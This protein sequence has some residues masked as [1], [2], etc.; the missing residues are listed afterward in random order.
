MNNRIKE[1]RKNTGY[2][3]EKFGKVIGVSRDTIANIEA[4]RIEIKD[5]FITSICREFSI[6]EEWLRTGNGEMK[7][8]LTRNQEVADFADELMAEVDESFKKRLII[9]LSKLN[10]SDWEVLA[11]IADELK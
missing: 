10:A 8:A 5:I 6:N 11:K 1:I 7:M 4:G 9:A 3:Q 2:S